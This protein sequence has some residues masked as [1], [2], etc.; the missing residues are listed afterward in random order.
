[1]EINKFIKKMQWLS[2]LCFSLQG[3][4]FYLYSF[5]ENDPVYIIFGNVS[6]ILCLII[7]SIMKGGV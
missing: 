2:V 3:F 1:M 6:L 4:G 7:F 5:I